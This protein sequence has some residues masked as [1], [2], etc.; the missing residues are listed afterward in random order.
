MKLFIAG[1]SRSGKSLW[2]QRLAR[3]LC[4]GG[5]PLYY[6]A[7]MVP[8]DEEDKRR[9]AEHRAERAGWGFQTEEQ[10][11]DLDKLLTRCSPCG[12]FLIDSVTALLANEMFPAS[13]RADKE[14]YRRVSSCMVNLC[15]AVEHAVVVSDFIFSDAG[16]FDPLTEQYRAG[17]GYIGRQVAAVCD[18]VLESVCGRLMVYKGRDSL[19][20]LYHTLV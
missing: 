2:G 12:V 14:A 10:P 3:A 20:S 7:T 16:C 6:V 15:V 17:L 4:S 18:I 5:R 13:G 8:Q 19:D 1:G 11:V 9:V